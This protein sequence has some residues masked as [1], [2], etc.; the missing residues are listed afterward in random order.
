MITVFTD[1]SSKGNPGRGGW[2]AI[3][4]T[5]NDVIELGGREKHTTNNRMELT[6]CIKALQEIKS[7][8]LGK[9]VTLFSDSTYVVRG[10]TEWIYVWQK[11]GWKTA[12][13][14]PVEN[15]DLWEEL[16]EATQGLNIEWKIIAG[17]AGI[18]AN[19]RCDEIATTFADDGSLTLYRNPRKSYKISLEWKNT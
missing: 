11:K 10:I 4:A 15:K 6:A 9:E 3:I 16:Y 13:K 2:G 14:K 17:H 5:E 8:K 19:E 12:A 7:S 18:M 1:G